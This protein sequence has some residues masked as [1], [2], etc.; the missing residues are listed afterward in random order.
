MAYRVRLRPPLNVRERGK[1][2]LSMPFTEDVS[3]VGVMFE[4]GSTPSY[5]V[6]VKKF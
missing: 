1:M 2:L 5:P 4:L 3:G 6:M